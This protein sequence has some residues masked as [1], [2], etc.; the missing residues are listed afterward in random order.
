MLDLVNIDLVYLK[1][2]ARRPR[3]EALATLPIQPY[4]FTPP[5]LGKEVAGD[6]VYPCFQTILRLAPPCESQT[7]R[8]FKAHAS[9]SPQG[10]N[11]IVRTRAQAYKSFPGD[12]HVQQVWKWQFRCFREER[13]G[14]S[15]FWDLS[16]AWGSGGHQ[17]NR[18]HSEGKGNEEPDRGFAKFL[19]RIRMRYETHDNFPQGLTAPL[20]FL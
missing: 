13:A 18:P 6:P 9:A 10:F 5:Y 14:K 17:H 7:L 2:L 19:S 15:D 11:S 3:Q 8:G 1:T 12:P 4:T 16:K 20:P